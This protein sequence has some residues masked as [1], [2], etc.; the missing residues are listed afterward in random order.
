MGFT[1]DIHGLVSREGAVTNAK[2]LD[3]SS[4]G[5]GRYSST[6][7]TPPIFNNYWAAS[8]ES[9][10]PQSSTSCPYNAELIV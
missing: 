6:D 8:Y 3:P 4:L 1:F 2:V 7:S 9:H 10:L 5:L